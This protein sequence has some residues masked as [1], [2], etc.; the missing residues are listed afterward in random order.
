[1]TRRA[2]WLLQPS[3]KRAFSAL[4]SLLV[5]ALSGITSMRHADEDAK[6]KGAKEKG[7]G[8]REG[9]GGIRTDTSVDENRK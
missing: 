1:M 2:T 4:C 9:G 3:S 6:K 8:V 5:C 7:G